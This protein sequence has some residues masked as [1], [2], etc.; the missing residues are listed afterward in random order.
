MEESRRVAEFEG[1]GHF[2]FLFPSVV[3][4]ELEKIGIEAR[5]I[6]YGEA[7]L[8]KLEDTDEKQTVLLTLHKK[9]NLKE[10]SHYLNM[11]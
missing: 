11:A 2:D 5:S 9:I 4:R 10:K 7:V 6:F 3:Y 8:E 1:V